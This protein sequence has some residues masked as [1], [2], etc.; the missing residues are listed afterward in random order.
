MAAQQLNCRQQYFPHADVTRIRG[1]PRF[2]TLYTLHTE[3][4]A[5]AASVPSAL[6][7]GQHGHLGLVLEPRAYQRISLT[8][9]L[10]PADPGALPPID[11]SMTWNQVQATRLLHN[12]QRA[13]FDKV[14]TVQSAL[15]QQISEAIEHEYLR[16][17]EHPVSKTIEAP[18][19]VIF[20]SL[21]EKYGK[22]TKRD[23]L[24]KFNEL[25]QYN[26]DPTRL[27]DSVFNKIDEYEKIASHA[28]SPITPPQKIDIG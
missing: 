21:F 7:G 27:P 24:E 2:E 5:N 22:I 28:K 20:A 14:Q 11:P 6:G 23:L 1:K 16:D 10:L 18:L 25:T 19:Y 12:D 9:F 8:A 4:K 15:K 13:A 26:Y 3:I 17:M